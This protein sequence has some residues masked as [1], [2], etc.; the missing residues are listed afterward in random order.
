MS[1]T[2]HRIL[3]GFGPAT[4][5]NSFHQSGVKVSKELEKDPGFGCAVFREPFE[6][7]KLLEFDALVFIKIIPPYDVLK[8]LKDAGKKLILDYQDMFLYPSVYEK[9]PLRKVLKKLYYFRLESGERKR[10]ALF[11]RCLVASPAAEAAVRETGMEPFFLERQIYNDRSRF[12]KKEYGN[13]TTGLTLYWTGVALNIDENRPIEPV[14]ERLCRR[15]S[16][17]VVY[18]TGHTG[19]PGS[20]DYAEYRGWSLDNW[21]DEMAAADIAFRWWADSNNQ[22]NK[23]SNKVISYMAAGL[24][25][26]CRPTLS[27]RRVARHGVNGFFAETPEEFGSMLERLMLDPLL[28]KRV[29]EAAFKEAWARF[30]LERHVA[31]LKGLLLDISS[32]KKGLMAV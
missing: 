26:I 22:H 21:E 11:D 8:R 23:D 1:T 6:I 10:F 15:R 18:H 30:S 2:R 3:V 16:S 28:R 12:I 9:D 25:V 29:G 19:G 13:N 27:D 17:K 7:E 32:G 5:A 14:L 24:P 31:C 4:T 20:A